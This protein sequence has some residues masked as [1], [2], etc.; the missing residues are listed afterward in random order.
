MNIRKFKNSDKIALQLPISNLSYKDLFYE[1]KGLSKKLDL[2][3][4][5]YA[6]DIDNSAAWVILDIFLHDTNKTHIPIPKFFNIEMIESIL[7]SAK[8]E[9]IV[10]DNIDFYI[11]NTRLYDI[12]IIII[13]T[14]TIFDKKLY[15]LKTIYG[16]EGDNFLKNVSKVTFTSGT[17]GQPKGICL[18]KNYIVNTVNSL[19]RIFDDIDHLLHL[20]ILP[21]SI[22]LENI[23]GIYVSLN[24]GKSIAIRN[25]K[26]LGFNGV[27]ILNK[28]TMIESINII[29]PNSIICYPEILNLILDNVKEKNLVLNNNNFIAVGGATTKTSLI[30]ECWANKIN[31][32]EGYGLSEC[33]SVVSLNSPKEFKDGTQG[34]ILDHHNYKIIKNELHIKNNGFMGYLSNGEIIMQDNEWTRTGDIVHIDSDRYL[35]IIGRKKNVLINSFGRNIFAKE[36]ES[37]FLNSGLF[38]NVVIVGNSRKYCCLFYWV[39]NKK[40]NKKVFTEVLNNIN[41]NLPEYSKI[42]KSKKIDFPIPKNLL[43]NNSIIRESFEISF[44]EIIDKLYNTGEI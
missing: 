23:A 18:S 33:C 27:K 3:Y 30:E 35:T 40:F 24:L 37:N 8:V 38:K 6:I 39:K 32:Y 22:L 7:K 21:Y 9:A 4:N 19:S 26:E 1:I 44:I 15:V 14:I 5:V 17:T 10:T 34:K 31:A 42:R 41:K 13:D 25:S 12:K 43:F 16:L 29:Q 11:N 28:K 20:S 2:R 36:I